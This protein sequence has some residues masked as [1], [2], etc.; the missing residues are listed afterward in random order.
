MQ[1]HFCNFIAEIR[2]WTRKLQSNL[3]HSDSNE[4]NETTNVL[5]LAPVIMRAI[6]LAHLR[7]VAQTTD[8]MLRVER[9]DNGQPCMLGYITGYT[10]L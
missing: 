3:E 10:I 7:E 2:N 6:A 1:Y 8:N 5:V 9:N 4:N